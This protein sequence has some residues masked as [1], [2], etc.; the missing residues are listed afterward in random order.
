M[1]IHVTGNIICEIGKI[2]LFIGDIIEEIEMPGD[3][4]ERSSLSLN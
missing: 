3:L 1:T 2:I 4:P